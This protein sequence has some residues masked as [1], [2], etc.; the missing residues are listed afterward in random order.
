M[1]ET[2]KHAQA[3]VSNSQNGWSDLVALVRDIKPREIHQ[4]SKVLAKAAG[5][6]H[7]T[8]KR[9]MEAINHAM[10]LGKTNE[11]IIA[12]GQ[13]KIMG[14]FVANQKGKRTEKLVKMTWLVSPELRDEVE[15]GLWNVGQALRSIRNEDVWQF[16]ASQMNTWSEEE[17]R[18]SAGEG[19]TK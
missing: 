13:K 4:A 8:L 16:L 14:A 15:R 18:H 11:E 2:E 19:Q 17:I 10:G 1:T 3:F 12:A 9:K 7:A 6:G 5:I